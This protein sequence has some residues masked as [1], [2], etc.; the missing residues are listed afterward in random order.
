MVATRRGPHRPIYRPQVGE[1]VR[2]GAHNGA[3]GVYMGEQSGRVYLRP[4]AGGV[5]WDTSP[6]DIEPL[7]P[8]PELV[9]VMRASRPRVAPGRPFGAQAQYAPNASAL[10]AELSA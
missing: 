6:S 1:M 4:K 7:S 5:E 9:P 3:Q 8:V 2:D 10:P